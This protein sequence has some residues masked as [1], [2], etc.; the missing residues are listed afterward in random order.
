MGGEEWDRLRAEALAGGAGEEESGQPEGAPSVED[1]STAPP[2]YSDLPGPAE[3]PDEPSGP[4]MEDPISGTSATDD[5]GVFGPE[6]TAA[7]L[8]EEEEDEEEAEPA[9]PEAPEPET[10]EAAAEHFATSM[11]PE[12]VERELLSDLG[13][14]GGT[15]TV[16]IEPTAPVVTEEPTWEEAGQPVSEE[17]EEAE[18][19]AAAPATAAPRNLTAALVSGGLLGGAVLVLLAI[20]KGPFVVLATLAVLLGQ[21]ELYAVM[22]TRGFSRPRC[23]GWCAVGSPSSGPTSRGRRR[24]CSDRRW[25]WGSPSPGTWPST[26]RP[27]G[28]WW[29][30]RRPRCSA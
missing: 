18:P 14:G 12:E 1:L 29:R 5:E 28:T 17:D 30:T 19:A 21:A 2:E 15:E 26:S 27:G 20:N 16:R 9:G 25:P 4:V 13:E 22:R 8:D 3:E 24:S 10:V 6:E 11:R 23:W 7:E